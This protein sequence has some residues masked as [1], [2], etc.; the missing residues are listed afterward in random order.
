M[1]ELPEVQ[2][3]ADALRNMLSDATLKKIEFL[4]PKIAGNVPA[5]TMANLLSG[6]TI[7][8]VTRRAKYILI[9]FEEDMLIVHLRMEGR[10]YV[11]HETDPIEKHSHVLLYL[12]DGTRVE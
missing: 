1:P 7:R 4:W 12:K 8:D 2:T 11:K 9:R 5:E 6:Q 3:V 10:F